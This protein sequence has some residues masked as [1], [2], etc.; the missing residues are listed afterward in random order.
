MAFPTGRVSS[1]EVANFGAPAGLGRMLEAHYQDRMKILGL[2]G[3]GDMLSIGRELGSKR[4][5]EI[6]EMQVGSPGF[7][8]LVNRQCVAVHRDRG[9]ELGERTSSRDHASVDE[10]QWNCRKR[11]RY[12]YDGRHGG[13]GS[14]LYAEPT[15]GRPG[16][17]RPLAEVEAERGNV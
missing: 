14:W 4:Q 3:L 10:W 7:L 1:I 5:V 17:M 6:R 13:T 15:Q 16:P 12:L 9:V 11:H 2:L 8:E